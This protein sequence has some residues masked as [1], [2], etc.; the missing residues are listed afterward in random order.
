MQEPSFKI[1]ILDIETS[2]VMS[3]VWGLFDQNIGLE[4]IVQDWYILAFSWKWLG[5]KDLIYKDKSKSWRNEDDTVLLK[6]L[7][8]LLDK[9]EVV[10]AH[11]G[12]QFDL[13]KINA[14]FALNGI[15][16]PSPYKVIDTKEVAKRVFGFTSNKLAFLTDK[17]CKTKKLTHGKF[18]GYLLWQQCL[19]GNPLAWKEMEKYNKADVL[20][21]EELY[22]VLRP[23]IS[24]H[25]NHG[26]FV[27]TGLPTC[28]RCGSTK[29]QRRGTYRTALS[30]YVRFQCL[31]CGGW[32]R[33]RAPQL[34]VAQRAN[35]RVGI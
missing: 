2:P 1:G 19:L 32:V 6:A 9:A 24:D 35:L 26:L 16:S 14:R 22:M 29:L 28:N 31:G 21:L 4:Q 3:A 27:D 25:P 18:P 20:S 12:K 7:W 10:V 23:W 13:K 33:G 30:Q 5:S 8:S 15:K 17:L 34:S 11:N